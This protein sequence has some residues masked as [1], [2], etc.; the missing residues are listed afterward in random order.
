MFFHGKIQSY[1]KARKQNRNSE[2]ISQ[3]VIRLSNATKIS[4]F[5]TNSYFPQL[6]QDLDPIEKKALAKRSESSLI[7][8]DKIVLL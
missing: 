8:A 1:S 6:I 4:I 3:E 7:R 5:M 2:N